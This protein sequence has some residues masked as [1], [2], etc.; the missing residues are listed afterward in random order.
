MLLLFYYKNIQQCLFVCLLILAIQA[1]SQQ[2]LPSFLNQGLAGKKLTRK[3]KVFKR[4]YDWGK[5][6]LLFPFYIRQNVFITTHCLLYCYYNALS[7]THTPRFTHS[8]SLSLA[9][10]PFLYFFLLLSPSLLIYYI[11]SSHKS[12]LVFCLVLF[13]TK[14]HFL[15]AFRSPN[16]SRVSADRAWALLSLLIPSRPDDNV[17]IFIWRS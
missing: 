1:R 2:A 7:L 10:P 4:G 12:S 6:Q 16:M 17:A 14:V 15:V 3:Y 9:L 11:I 8:L 13:R 5:R